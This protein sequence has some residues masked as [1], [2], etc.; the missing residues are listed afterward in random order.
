MHLAV[1]TMALDIR[2]KIVTGDGLPKNME[3][4]AGYDWAV[5]NCS[6][7]GKSIEHRNKL[8]NGYDNAKMKTKSAI[9]IGK[10][11]EDHYD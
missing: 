4:F 10:F 9:I 5:K 7:K 6:V 8:I 1:R 2:E 11:E 3:I